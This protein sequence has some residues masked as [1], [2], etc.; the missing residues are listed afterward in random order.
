MRNS[1]ILIELFALSEIPFVGSARWFADVVELR[2][3]AQRAAQL[4]LGILDCN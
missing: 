1:T 4:S 3:A 2:T